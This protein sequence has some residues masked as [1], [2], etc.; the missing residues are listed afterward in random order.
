MKSLQKFLPKYSFALALV[1]VLTVLF[2]I[3]RGNTVDIEAGEVTS[4]ELV[5]AIY[6]TGF[7]EADSFASLSVEYSGTVNYVGAR[8]G[9]R[10]AAGQKILELDSQRPMLA[11]KEAKA[12]LAEQQAVSSE[13]RRTYTRKSNLF[14]EGAI[15]RQELEDSEKNN[16]QS[17]ELLQQKIMQ[18]K[19]REDDLK[20][21]SVTAPFAG[22][23]TLQNIKKGDYVQANSLVA[24]VVDPT[25]FTVCVEVDEL[26]IPRIRVGQPATVALDAYPE[27]RMHASVTR[28]VPQTDK[29]TKTSKIYL[30][31][32]G[33][34]GAIQAGMTATANIIY[35]TK[36]HTILVRKSSV[37][38]ENHRSFVW[39]I[40]G[41]RLKKQ[42]VRLGASDMTFFEVLSGL[43]KG[44]K[45]AL[46]PKENL[47]E[48]MQ[49]KI[50][51]PGKS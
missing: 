24:T 46:V 40:D 28:I 42:P 7:V 20:K 4:S 15:S 23:L 13:N 33:D 14:R 30:T 44:D 37:F 19:Q 41:G 11:L 31:L 18:L 36:Q 39:K 32:D 34:A 51:N 2:L 8:E 22:V 29:I 35:S 5:Q 10:V 49:V 21:L 48:G 43:G 45:V 1:L 27:K 9:E 50:V 38:E 25:H 12:A 6:A 16:T 17:A 26:D 3:F 47:H